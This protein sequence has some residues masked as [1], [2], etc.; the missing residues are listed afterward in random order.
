MNIYRCY[1]YRQERHDPQK[2]ASA[3]CERQEFFASSPRVALDLAFA[4]WTANEA[5]YDWDFPP[6]AEIHAAEWDEVKPGRVK[7]SAYNKSPEFVRT[8]YPPQK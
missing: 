3:W 7:W 1:F 4:F 6:L 8:F 2:R 5:L